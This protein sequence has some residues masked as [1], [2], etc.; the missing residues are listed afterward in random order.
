MDTSDEGRF[1]VFDSNASNLVA[2]DTNNDADL[3]V[4]D[5]Q[6]GTTERIVRGDGDQ[7]G[8][9]AHGA[10][11]GNGRYVFSSGHGFDDI[12][13]Q[14]MLGVRPPDRRCGTVRGQ[15][16]VPRAAEPRRHLR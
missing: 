6:T 1:V 10:I 5:R 12:A 16:H 4:H 8:R 13:N 14:G 2:A 15:R 7:G 11:S 9:A 3:F